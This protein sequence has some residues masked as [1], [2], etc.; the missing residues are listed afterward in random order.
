[1]ERPN[2]EFATNQS[3]RPDDTFLKLCS[4]GALVVAYRQLALMER[5]GMF[6]KPATVPQ[7]KFAAGNA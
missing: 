7:Q 1:M 4:S 2:G 6:K 3:R 5:F